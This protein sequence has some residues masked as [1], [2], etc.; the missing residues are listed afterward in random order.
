[1]PNT[2]VKGDNH[3]DSIL[4]PALYVVKQ[5]NCLDLTDLPKRKLFAEKDLFKN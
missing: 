1:M 2:M 3:N 4:Y 5:A